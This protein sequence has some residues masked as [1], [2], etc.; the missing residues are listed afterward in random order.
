[1]KEAVG[2]LASG[3]GLRLSEQTLVPGQTRGPA[4]AP[5][6]GLGPRSRTRARGW[7]LKYQSTSFRCQGGG[8]QAQLGPGDLRTCQQG[9]CEGRKA[10]PPPH[11][12]FSASKFSAQ[13]GSQDRVVASVL[14]GPAPRQH[15][16]GVPRRLCA[17]GGDSSS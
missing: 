6:L 11:Q 9:C 5:A 7:S 4:V 8:W 16:L 12:S 3:R 2:E 14:W 13:E 15:L 10:L 17:G 1:M